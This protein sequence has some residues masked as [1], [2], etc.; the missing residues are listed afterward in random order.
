MVCPKVLG[1]FYEPIR[2]CSAVPARGLIYSDVHIY[3]IPP[4]G[5]K[6]CD[7]WRKFW[8][9]IGVAATVFNW[10]T[11][12][13][14]HTLL[15][16][17]EVEG[18]DGPRCKFTFEMTSFRLKWIAQF[19]NQVFQVRLRLTYCMYVRRRRGD[20]CRNQTLRP[21]SSRLCSIGVIS[22]NAEP[23]LFVCFLFVSRRGRFCWHFSNHASTEPLL[24]EGSDEA[25]G[26]SHRHVEPG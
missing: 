26:R 21:L 5:P 11:L 25:E 3:Y 16:G 22:A 4:L 7:R 8:R 2:V 20:V 9:W 17:K 19:V 23:F 6:K 1:C 15:D 14:V 13:F 24:P 18:F 12:V 10:F